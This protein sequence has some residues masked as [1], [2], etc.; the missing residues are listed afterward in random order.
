MVDVLFISGT[1]AT[2]KYV[3][4]FTGTFFQPRAGAYPRGLHP[5]TR[6][7]WQIKISLEVVANLSGFL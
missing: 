7:Y 3:N 4:A 1:V 2:A 6:L 5:G